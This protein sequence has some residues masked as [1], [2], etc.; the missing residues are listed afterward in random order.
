MSVNLF[1]AKDNINQKIFIHGT[2]FC[3]Q[4]KLVIRDQ[5]FVVHDK[6]IELISL[7]YSLTLFLPFFFL[8][9]KQPVPS[10]WLYRLRKLLSFGRSHP[11]L[12]Q[13][14]GDPQPRFLEAYLYPSKESGYLRQ[15]PGESLEP[16]Y[17]TGRLIYTILF[18]HYWHIHGKIEFKKV[19]A[20]IRKG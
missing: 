7:G 20:N 3:L 17:W 14:P 18:V 4:C 1:I 16:K 13:S 5:T 8:L 12:I 9:L 10:N 11:N 15:C 19:L 2:T 6:P